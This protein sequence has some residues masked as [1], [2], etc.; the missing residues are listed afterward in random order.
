MAVFAM[1]SLGADMEAG[2][3]VEWMI[4]PGDT[5]TRGDVVAVVETQKGA[6]EIECF[7]EGTVE[8][9]DAEIGAT[10]AVGAP[11]ATIRAPGKEV[12]PTARPAPPTAPAQ[13]EK[14]AEAPAPTASAPLPTAPTPPVVPQVG[15]APPASPAARVL[16]A[17]RGIDLAALTG[18][19]PG[20]AVLLADVEAAKAAPLAEVP[21]KASAKPGLDMA[22]MRTAIANAMARSKREIP[23]YYLTQTVDLQVAIDWLTATNAARTPDKRLLMGALFVKASAL[24]AA[25]IAQL[26][27]HY[28]AEGFHPAKGV[29]A[30]IAV[31]L[32]GGGLVAPALHDAETLPLDELM[33]QMRDLV[34]RARIGRLRSSEMTDGT[35]TISAMGDTGADA[36]AAVIYPPQVAIVGFGAPLVRPWIIGDTIAPRMTVTVTLS[37]DHRVSDGRRGA[38]FLSA[39][40]AALQTPET[41]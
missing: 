9:L 1:P 6:I 29:H 15:E 19:G 31:A 38:K 32:R 4:K 28:D 13:P 7:E 22:A 34:A 12:A 26:N 40:D 11:L 30:G 36:M 37:A 23:H 24:A 39:I 27:G 41:L 18:T 16:A 14:P 21:L 17:E 10:V 8:T 3:L 33:T 35:I 5:V 20:G 2:T 25:Q